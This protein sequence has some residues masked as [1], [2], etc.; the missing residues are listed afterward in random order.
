MRERGGPTAQSGIIYQNSIAALYLG[1]LCDI[2]P[3]P[4]HERICKVRVEA[5]EHVDDIVITFADGHRIYVQ[6]KENIRS[7]HEAWEKLWRDFAAQF[8]RVDFQRGKDRLAIYIGEI[9]DEHHQLR[10]LCNR[11]VDSESYIEWGN[12]LTS[13]QQAL[14]EKVKPLLGI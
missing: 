4:E 12:R 5:P 3:R 9:Y 13:T 6:A 8:A 10:E 14:I 7:H 11:A 1:R 2:T